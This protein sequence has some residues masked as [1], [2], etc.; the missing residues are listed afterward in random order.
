[1][2]EAS[3]GVIAHLD[4]PTVADV[5]ALAA[6][7]EQAGADWVGVADAFWWRDTWMLLAEAVK[8]T[9]RIA[10]GPMVTNPYL[11]HPFHTLSALATLQEL[12]GDRVFLGLG[13]GGSEV[14]GAAGISRR[15]APARVE[16]LAALVRE[17]AAGAP[18]DAASGRRLDVPLA[19]L[20]VQVAGRGD[21]VLRAAGRCAD[22]AVLWA[23]PT[24]DVER[25]AD[26]V[27]SGAQARFPGADPSGPELVWAPL[28]VH[29][30]G[31]APRARAI[32]A[33]GV[34]NA[35]AHLRAAWGADDD[36]VRDVRAALLAGGASAAASLVPQRVVDDI[37][38]PDPEPD[39]HAAVAARVGAR[40]MA[41]PAHDLAVIGDRVAWA[42]EVLARAATARERGETR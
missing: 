34:L 6:A 28:V 32:A 33:Y 19:P 39:R 35:G 11:R 31:D 38:A 24:S 2:S 13:A 22:R 36:L 8:V 3:V 10:V 20:P 23:V 26:V 18:L 16:A 12:A 42:R 37:A 17:V 14:S 41:V 27:R 15:D 40:H 30:P 9:E 1:V 5:R 25:S 4:N 21:R 7:A 29:G